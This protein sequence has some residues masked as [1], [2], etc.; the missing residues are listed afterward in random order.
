MPTGAIRSS[1]ACLAVETREESLTVKYAFMSFSCPQLALGELLATARRFGYDGVEPRLD[2]QH[3]HGIE[4]TADAARRRAIRREVA[5][6]GVALAA[7]ATSC[8]Y[9]D[10]AKTEAS[11]LHTRA[12]LRLAA[13]IGAPRLR[14]FG[15]TMPADQTRDAAV[16][17]VAG[18]LRSLADEARAAGVDLCMETH[19][20][21][22]RP[23]DVVAVMQRVDHPAVGVN[24]DLMHPVRR[25]GVTMD[26]AFAAL[27]PWIRHVHLHDGTPDPVRLLPIGQ[28]I[29]D[30]RRA[31]ELL[32]GMPFTGFLSG[33]WIGW[34]DPFEVHLPRELAT[35]KDYERVLA[36]PR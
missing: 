10:P 30:H 4:T 7:L 12:C 2:A 9:A 33:E 29:V 35:L 16:A 31:L 34:S 26:E 25:G 13:E 3:A 28:G 27:R 15:G 5:A 24:W 18:A 32:A 1:S 20:S 17:I 23:A 8:V 14:V 21:W 11:V 6:S 36:R 22:C 19:D